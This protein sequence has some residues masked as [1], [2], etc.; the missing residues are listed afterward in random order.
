MRSSGPIA[1]MHIYIRLTNATLLTFEVQACDDLINV[2]V[3]VQFY[4]WFNFSFSIVL[5]SLS[6]INIEKNNEI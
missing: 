3:V 1:L 6:Y 5:Y 2:L 4:P